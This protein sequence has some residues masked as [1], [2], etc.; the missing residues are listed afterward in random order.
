MSEEITVYGGHQPAVVDNYMPV[1]TVAHAMERRE[2]IKNFV[3]QAMTRDHDYGIIPGTP[4]PTLLKPGA[5]KLCNLFGLSPSFSCIKEDE[6]WTGDTHGGEPFFNY[7]YVCRLVRNS[8][9]VGEG[10]GSCNSWEK[11]YRYRDSAPTC[12]TCGA[13][14]IAVSKPEYG[15]GYYCNKRKG[16]CG[17]IFVKDDQAIESQSLGR[18]PNPDI[19][20][21]VNTI[22]KMAQKRALI[23]ATLIA[24][25]ASEFFTQDRED[26][27]NGGK[28]VADRTPAPQRTNGNTIS[29]PQQKRLFALMK[30]GNKTQ[31]DVKTIIERHGFSHTNEITRDKYEAICAEICS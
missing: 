1:A 27:M 11:K 25:S 24:C 6:D 14:A 3:S 17:A 12:P 16:G 7:K 4:K 22:Q 29:D 23:A 31:A 28:P 15:G 10:E 9:V 20:D 30:Q 19:A 8:V 5:E 21:Q 26:L 13:A 2:I 18:V